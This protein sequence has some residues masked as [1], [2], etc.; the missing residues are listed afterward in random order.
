MYQNHICQ[1][2]NWWFELV[3]QSP[4][5]RLVYVLLYA[6]LFLCLHSHH[7]QEQLYFKFLYVTFL[8]NSEQACFNPKHKILTTTHANDLS[9]TMWSAETVTICYTTL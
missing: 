6:L 9:L 4:E 5:A 1:Y 3:T 7:L 2:T 8:E